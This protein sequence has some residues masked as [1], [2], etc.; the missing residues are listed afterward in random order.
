MTTHTL[1]P[2][3]VG[4][5]DDVQSTYALTGDTARRACDVLLGGLGPRRRFCPHAATV[6]EIRRDRPAVA[7]PRCDDHRD[8]RLDERWAVVTI[9]DTAEAQRL[10]IA[11]AECRHIGEYAAAQRLDEALDDLLVLP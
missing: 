6:S 2:R 1:N 9:R 3:P 11:Y 4:W 7:H 5:D 8:D 10:L